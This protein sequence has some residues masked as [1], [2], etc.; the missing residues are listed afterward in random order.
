MPHMTIPGFVKRINNRYF[1]IIGILV[2]AILLI[3]LIRHA[4]TG[5]SDEVVA[6]MPEGGYEEVNSLALVDEFGMAEG[7]YMIRSGV[8]GSRQTLSHILSGFDLTAIEIEQVADLMQ[9]VFS[10]RL[11][12][13]G[14]SF[15]G[16]YH[17][18][19]PA[20]LQYFIYEISSLEFL[21]IDFTDSWKVMR[22]EKEVTSVKRAASGFINS[23]LWNAMSA[24]GLNP[25]LAIRMSEILAWEVDFY[26]IQ[27]GDRFKVVYH[28]D[29]VGNKSVGVSGID[30]I[31]FMNHGREIYG[32]R[33]E[34]DTIDGFFNGDGENLRKVFLKAPIEFY[35]ISS[36]YSHSRLHPVLNQRRPHLGTDYAAPHG[37]PILAVGDGVVTQAAYHGGNGN[38]VRIR[39]NSI[40]ETQ[41]L[42]MSRFAS[43]IRPGARVTQ[44]QVIGYVGSTGLA[45]GPHVCF[46][47]WKHGR[48]VD[49]LREEFPSADPLPDAYY[50]DF[51]D[52]RDRLMK[53]LD[54]L[55][56]TAENVR[57]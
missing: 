51:S 11:I 9:G 12:R 57:P 22:L 41:Y 35:R 38:Y 4:V 23:S 20:E 1:V 36:R 44:G 40:Y 39:H 33:F 26:R 29:F 52:Q 8:V 27:A 30:A 15:F 7:Q 32:F 56:F 50:E 24:G 49:H 19:E 34:Q 45:T 16:Y 5:A 17:V 37:T 3:S 28:E 46:R 55:S 54:Y 31:Y 2:S 18:N 21:K 25:E 6:D 14:Q 13:S 42:H 48:Q 43:G 47:F 53:I 10:P